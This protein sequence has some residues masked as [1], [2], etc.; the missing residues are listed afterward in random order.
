MVTQAF[1]HSVQNGGRW[2][3]T[4]DAM[5]RANG[6]AG[7]AEARRQGPSAVTAPRRAREAHRS[8]RGASPIGLNGWAAE[9]A[10]APEGA[11]PEGAAPTRKVRG[12]F[13]SG[14]S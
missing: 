9:G 2:Q 6:R 14:S 8:Y 11:A 5:A 10:G 13:L 3:W 4:A 7:A 1:R 12:R